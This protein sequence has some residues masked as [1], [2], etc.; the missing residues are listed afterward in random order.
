MTDRSEQVLSIVGT[1]KPTNLFI[2]NVLQE[3][4]VNNWRSQQF[5]SSVGIDMESAVLGETFR[6]HPGFHRGA[7]S[8]LA[9]IL[10]SSRPDPPRRCRPRNHPFDPSVGR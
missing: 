1:C 7:Q 6:P 8:K 2:F 10:Q 9:A 3:I 5:I 4:S